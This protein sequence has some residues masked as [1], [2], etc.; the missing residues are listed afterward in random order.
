MIGQY[1]NNKLLQISNVNILL[2]CKIY[3]PTP[4][5]LHTQHETNDEMNIVRSMYYVLFRRMSTQGGD[6]LI[7]SSYVD[8]GPAF[9]IHPPKIS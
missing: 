5:S 7:F 9:T 8:S 1:V 6:T 3:R 2:Y 4:P